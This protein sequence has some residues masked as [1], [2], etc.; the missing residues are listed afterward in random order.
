[1]LLIGFT[2]TPICFE[3]FHTGAVW[4]LIIYKDSRKIS[5]F[6]RWNVESNEHGRKKNHFLHLELTKSLGIIAFIKKI[7]LNFDVIHFSK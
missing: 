4:V 6:V 3:P 1:M 5:I 7:I 2:L